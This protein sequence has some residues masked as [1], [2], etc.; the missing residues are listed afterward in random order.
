MI[1]LV[2]FYINWKIPLERDDPNKNY[3]LNN[4]SKL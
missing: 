2:Q 3:I 4:D 1:I